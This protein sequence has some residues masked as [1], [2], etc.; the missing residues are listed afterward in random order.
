MTEQKKCDRWN[1]ANPIGT[2]VIVWRDNGT[3]FSTITRSPALVADCGSAV[4]W[5]ENISGYYS[6]YCV[7]PLVLPELDK[8]TAENARLKAECNHLRS[9]WTGALVTRHQAEHPDDSIDMAYA[10]AEGIVANA[11]RAFAETMARMEKE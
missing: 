2:P 6:L 5:L 9:Q 8:L 11:V 7:R 10:V 4:I 3:S 1:E